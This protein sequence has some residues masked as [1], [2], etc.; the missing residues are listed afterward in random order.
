MIARRCQEC[1]TKWYSADTQAWK[2]DKCGAEIADR[3]G[4]KSI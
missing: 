1:N 3:G 4:R 2:C